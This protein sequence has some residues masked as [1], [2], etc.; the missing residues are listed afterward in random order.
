LAF[1]EFIGY[2]HLP[3]ALPPETPTR[4]SVSA[5]LGAEEA[6]DLFVRAIRVGLQKGDDDSVH[7]AGVKGQMQRMDPAVTLPRGRARQLSDD[8]Q[9]VVSA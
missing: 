8:A 6:T 7:A 3:G 4:R 5:D 2:P 9:F 1:S